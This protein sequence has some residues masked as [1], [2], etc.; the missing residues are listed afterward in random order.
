MPRS[1]SAIAALQKLE[2]DREALDT[3]QRELE[4]LAAREVGQMILGTGLETFSRKGLRR[5][6]V[7]LAQRGEEASMDLL[8]SGPNTPAKRPQPQ[9]S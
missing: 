3:K 4:D 1:K 2:A 8:F 7:E 9:A 6:A 5:I